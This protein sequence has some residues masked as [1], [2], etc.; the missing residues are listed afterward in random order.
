MDMNQALAAFTAL[1]QETR[2]QVFRRLVQAGVQGMA[3][4]D[5][6][7]V[8][9]VRQNTM[10]ANLAVLL[11]AGVVRNRR[12]GRSIRYFVD[13]NG[14]RGLLSFLLE[15]C[16]GGQ[17]ELCAPLIENIACQCEAERHD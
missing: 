15:D 10:S 11:N 12:E 2:M 7:E 14:L 4:G 6:A 5:L 9:D 8:L 17:A 13:M 1:S 3:A 16:C